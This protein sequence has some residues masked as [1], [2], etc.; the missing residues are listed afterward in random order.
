VIDTDV[1]IFGGGIAGLWMLGRLRRAGYSALLLESGRLGGVQTPAS[2]GIIHGGTK[3]ALAG[4]LTGSARSIAAMPGIWRDCLDGHGELDLGAVELLSDHQ[5]LWSTGKPASDLVGF[6]ASHAMRSRVAEADGAARPQ[7]LQSPDFKG[8]VYRLNEPVLDTMSLL[9]ELT[10]QLGDACLAYAADPGPRLLEGRPPA[11]EVRHPEGGT[12]RLRARR[13]V[14]AAGAGNE[15]LL[16]ALG[17]TKPAMQ[18]RPLHMLMLKGPLPDLYAHCLGAG[19]NPRLTITTHRRAD[20]SQVWY[21]GGQIAESGVSRSEP[22]QIAEGR[23]ELATILP[24]LDLAQCRWAG[25]R[26]DRAEPRQAGGRRP[27]HAFLSSRD[28][29]SVAWPTKLAFAPAL[30]ADLLQDLERAGIEPSL[31]AG[32]SPDWPRPAAAVPPWEARREWS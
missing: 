4:K 28:G 25:F 29:V 17:W 3:Y 31:G 14:L 8:H 21:L 19:T 5:Y 22:E 20:G 13:T 2:Q 9:R 32:E 24:W 30:A 11:V 15:R 7:A 23:R 10:R 6:F 27:D 12:L 1:L 26:I 16:A 18:R